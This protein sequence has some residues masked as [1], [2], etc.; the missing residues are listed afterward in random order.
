MAEPFLSEIRLVSF[1]FA[2]RGW[3]LANGQLM[4][5]NQNQALFSLLSTMYGGDGVTTFALP[6]YRGRVPIHMGS[7]Y[8]VGQSGGEQTHTLTTDEIPKHAHNL[9][10]IDSGVAADLPVSAND[11]FSNT[12]PNSL[13]QNGRNNLVALNQKS[14]QNT[15]GN[16][17]HQNMQPFLTVSFCVALQGIFPSQN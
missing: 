11:L 17:P 15:G 10:A 2:P 3:A 16:Q 1:N 6:D 8:I 9:L 4:P 13:Y 7:G 5:I 14:V 12:K